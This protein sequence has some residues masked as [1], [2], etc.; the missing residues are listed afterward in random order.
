MA[1][2]SQANATKTKKRVKRKVVDGKA[3]IKSTFNNTIISICDKQGNVIA[4]SSAG[5]NDFKNSRKS[6]A[7]AAGIAAEKAVVK[8]RDENG[9]QTLEVSVYGP[10]QGREA[11][12][13]AFAAAGIIVKEIVEK[14]GVAHNGCRPRKY[15]RV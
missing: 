11:A 14:T 12:M 9:L 3:T 5:A 7:F 6:T 13:R 2:P 4:W 8:A 10:G 15:R 1:K